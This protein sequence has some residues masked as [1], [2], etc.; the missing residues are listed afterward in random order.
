MGE[1]SRIVKMRKA[2]I[3]ERN[4]KI[5]TR[6]VNAQAELERQLKNLGVEVKPKFTIEPPLGRGKT[7]LANRNY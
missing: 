3:F 7:R 5:D 2:E 1:K 6:L 4:R